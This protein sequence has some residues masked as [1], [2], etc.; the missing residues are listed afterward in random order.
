VVIAN[1]GPA[2]PIKTL[3]QRLMIWTRIAIVR[4]QGMRKMGEVL[5]NR[6]LPGPEHAAARTEFIERWAANDPV[7]YL[8]ALKGLVNWSVLDALPRIDRPLLVLTGDQD[9]TPLP[10]KRAYAAMI[11][12]AELV[13]LDDSRHFSPI[14]QAAAFNAALIEFLTRVGHPVAL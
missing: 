9:Y 10:A 12:D 2:M 5:A 11:T 13:G 7:A 1:S 6:L 8:S 14:D 4:L 3:S